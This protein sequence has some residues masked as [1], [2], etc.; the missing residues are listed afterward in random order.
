MHIDLRPERNAIK[1]IARE[2][3][4]QATVLCFDEFQVTDVADAVI[5][6]SLFGEL[7]SEC[8]VVMVATSNRAPDELYLDGINR[9]YFLPFIDLLKR[10]CVCVDMDSERD[11]RQAFAKKDGTYFYPLNDETHA[12]LDHAFLTLTGGKRGGPVDIPV[13]MGRTLKVPEAVENVCRFT[14]EDLCAKDVFAA[15]YKAI[16]ENFE[17]VV[18]EGVKR[19]S[20]EKHNEARRFITLVDVL[21]EKRTR[22]V[23]SAEVPVKELFKETKGENISTSIS[24]GS[25]GGETRVIEKHSDEEEKEEKGEKGKRKE[26]ET[27]MKMKEKDELLSRYVDAAQELVVPEGEL[28]SVKELGFAF[29]R[30]ASRLQ[31]MASY[32]YLE[33]EA[34]GGGGREFE[35]ERRGEKKV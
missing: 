7:W 14:F 3:G 32:E 26:E 25:L 29:Q 21:Y 22:L 8:G 23:M 17:V 10:Q 33:E 6:A 19:L 13:M 1:Q 2:I 30:A 9:P 18:L 24:D 16:C 31:E 20:T 15:D 28:A 27:Q 12:K 35:V 5:M 11:H 34:D 4:Q